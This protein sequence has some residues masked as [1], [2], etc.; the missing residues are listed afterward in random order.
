MLFTYFCYDELYEKDRYLCVNY[1]WRCRQPVLAKKQKQFS[2]AIY[3]HSRDGEIIVANDLRSVSGNL[4]AGKYFYL[5][6]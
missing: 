6:Q 1:G 5:I 3:R 2:K 4:P